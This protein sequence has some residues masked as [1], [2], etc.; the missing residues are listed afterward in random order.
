MGLTF[1]PLKSYANIIDSEQIILFPAVNYG[2]VL[3]RAS[4]ANEVDES[5]FS[6]V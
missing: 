4:R 6:D 2:F 5:L 3:S 1:N